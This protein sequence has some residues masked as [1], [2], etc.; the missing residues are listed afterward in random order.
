MTVAITGTVIWNPPWVEDGPR[1]ARDL[2]PT[3]GIRPT[4]YNEVFHLVGT[5]GCSPE[6]PYW[7]WEVCG[8]LDHPRGKQLVVPGDR[9]QVDD[10]GRAQGIA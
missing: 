3:E 2:E 6:A 10:Y 1:L 8:I 7:G 9:I 4:T 5:S